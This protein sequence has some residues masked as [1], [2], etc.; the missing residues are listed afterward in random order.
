MV[1]EIAPQ[2][3]V[4]AVSYTCI[5]ISIS[6][7]FFNCCKLLGLTNKDVN[8]DPVGVYRQ[9]FCEVKGGSRVLCQSGRK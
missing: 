3:S 8:Y 9:L 6:L 7:F 2:E 1:F 4:K 5:N